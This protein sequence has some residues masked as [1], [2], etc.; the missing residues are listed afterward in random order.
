MEASHQSNLAGFVKDGPLIPALR[1]RFAIVSI[2]CMCLA[3]CGQPGSPAIR[4]QSATLRIGQGFD[5]GGRLQ[6]VVQIL[7]Q[8][9]LL[10]VTNDGRP[11]P[12]LVKSWTLS[13]DGLNW[14][15]EL[16]PNAVFHDGTPLTAQLVRELL[17]QELPD[18]LGPAF[19]N[20]VSIDPISPTQ[21][22]IVLKHRS[23]FLP[24]A[25]ALNV[26]VRLPE[27]NIGTGPFSL[28]KLDGNSAE[29][30]ANEHYY[31][32][33]PL[34]DRILIQPYSSVRAAWAD[35]LRG[36]V[37]MVYEIGVDAFDSVKPATETKL[38]MYNR[39]YAY[40]IVLN[41]RSPVLKDPGLRRALNSAIDRDKFV[42]ETLAGHGRAADGPIWPDH[43]TYGESR[44]RFRYEPQAVAS[45][46]HRPTFTCLYSDP[47]YEKMAIFV[48]QEL[49]AI[50]VD[51][52]LE[53]TSVADGL[54]RAKAGN[55]DAWLADTNLAPNFF[56]QSLFWHSRSGYN[57]GHYESAKADGALDAMDQ[58]RSDAEY[59][60][61]ADAFQRA[62]V[63]DPPAIFLAWSDRLRA[64]STR[65][66]VHEE[67]GRDILNTL[68]LWRPL[69]ARARSTN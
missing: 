47:S 22:S 11:G 15:L 67:P 40:V 36:G 66:E 31:Q 8:E 39:P 20:V 58:A 23:R 45:S 41:L 55:F 33:R 62:I 53:Y 34:I 24:E 13:E 30:R 2:A 48:Q 35:M 25:L 61:G 42:E 54:A 14:R 7:T 9:G 27:S 26:P 46:G 5:A 50:G 51:M 38:F 18:T 6:Q 64:V 57:W 56:R 59:K 69:G 37:D 44:A 32:G 29:F 12:R 28:E 68:R 10:S 3:G 43:W 1:A 4:A 49:Q 65:F 21:F 17:M 52:R 16:Q 19:Q 60:E 63:D